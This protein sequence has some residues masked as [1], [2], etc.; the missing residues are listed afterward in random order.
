[1]GTPLPPAPDVAKLDFR[2]TVGDDTQVHTILHVLYNPT[3]SPLS[4]A[5]LAALAERAE[6]AWSNT[7]IP[8][9]SNVTTFDDV[10]VTDLST[11]TGG[12]AVE[13][14]ATNGSDAFGAV[15]AAVSMCVTGL[16]TNRGRSYRSRSYIAG[17]PANK[18]Q[19][20]QHWNATIV[21]NMHTAFNNLNAAL[22]VATAPEVYGL[23]MV[24]YYSGYATLVAGK[25]PK[26][27]RRLGGPIVSLITSFQPK[28]LVASQRRRNR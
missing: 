2:Q 27:A 11:L 7:I 15:P 19:D 6:D 26:P 24:S 28:A 22:S 4:T 18:L 17:L 23:C 8:L 21:T 25:R 9:Q 10:T 13:G 5:N 1:M 12:Q 16:T 20:V 3:F 14:V